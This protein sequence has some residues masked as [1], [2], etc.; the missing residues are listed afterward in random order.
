MLSKGAHSFS[1]LGL[2]QGYKWRRFSS[3][4][5]TVA[6]KPSKSHFWRNS[7]LLIGLSA[8]GLWLGDCI[9]NDDFD[10][11]V[12][13]RFRSRLSEQERLE[14]YDP[15]LLFVSIIQ[16]L[17]HSIPLVIKIVEFPC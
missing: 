12:V 9:L 15:V 7:A 8:V 17:V 2:F 13:E 1:K 5:E 3:P 10:T 6:Q 11:A 4:T 16:L 14:R